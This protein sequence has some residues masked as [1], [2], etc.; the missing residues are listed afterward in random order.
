MKQWII[1]IFWRVFALIVLTTIIG[2]IYETSGRRQAARDFPPPGQL[3]DIGGRRIHLDCRG[4]GSPT[5]IFESGLDVNGSLSWSV[6]HDEI[7]K[8]TRACAYSR[9]GIM[10]SDPHDAPQNGKS[11]A[12]DLHAAL[13]NAGEQGPF[14]LVGHSL[15]GPYIMTYTKYFGED[16]AGL[17][18][19]DASYP[20]QEQRFK[21]LNI[22]EPWTQKY[23]DELIKIGVALNWTG[24]IRAFTSLYA[25]DPKQPEHDDLAMKAYISTS[26]GAMLK[27]QAALEQTLAEAG[28][29]R[30][31]GDRPL[32]VLTAMK[33]LP[34]EALAELKW[35]EEQ[36]K[37]SQE[38]WKQMHV[39]QA[40][41][42]TNSQ[43]QL[44]P[45]ANHYIQFDRPDVVIAAVR[46][47]VEQVRTSRN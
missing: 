8:T 41:W 13:N 5:V 32:F 17:V 2:V 19:V 39:E 46:W 12:E 1:Y 47:V 15:G 18:F 31:L 25:R 33:P 6:I 26:L 35:S 24:V 20:E 7:A 44:V 40:A 43:H 28:T 21:A 29:F 34:V 36:A 14:V 16:V 10:W 37:Q 22:P 11:I 27:E 38:A 30:K 3:V 45:D 4:S 23:E 42:S 9:A